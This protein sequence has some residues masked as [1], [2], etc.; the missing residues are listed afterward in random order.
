MKEAIERVAF[1]IAVRMCI[2]SW[3]RSCVSAVVSAVRSAV[4][5]ASKTKQ[6]SLDEHLVLP[7]SVVER[8]VGSS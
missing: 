2:G 1:S 7:L 4:V 6:Q 3:V 8:E 5:F